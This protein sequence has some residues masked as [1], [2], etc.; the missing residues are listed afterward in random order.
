MDLLQSLAIVGAASQLVLVN[1]KLAYDAINLKVVLFFSSS[2]MI[3]S[4]YTTDVNV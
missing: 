3:M 2:F 1:Y 4:W